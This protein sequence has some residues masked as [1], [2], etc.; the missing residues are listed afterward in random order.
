VGTRDLQPIG[1]GWKKKKNPGINSGQPARQGRGKKTLVLIMGS[2][3][4]KGGEKKTLVLT[5]GWS[6]A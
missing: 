5:L 3:S 6:G 2:P 1:K 4:E